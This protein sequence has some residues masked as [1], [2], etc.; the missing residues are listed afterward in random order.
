MKQKLKTSFSLSVP[1]KRI[2]ELDFLKGIAFLI[3]VWDH[4]VFD[5]GDLFGV[6]TSKLGFFENGIGEIAAVIFMTVCGVSITLG[7]HN[8][9]RG[10]TVFSLAMLLTAGTYIA[11]YVM[12]AELVILFGILHFLGLA[13][14]IGHFVKKLPTWAIPL[15][16]IEAFALNPLVKE[17][18]INT[19]VFFPIGI[20]NNLFYSSDYFP[21]IPNLGYVFIGIFIGKV[22]YKKKKSLFRHS[23]KKSFICCLGR[24]TLLLYFVHQPI[25][26]G[27]LY[28]ISFTGVFK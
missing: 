16:V 17:I 20:Y 14:I 18:S 10:L 22:F 3:M 8:I 1:S 26:Y 25:I 4:V 23:P 11:G 6:N 15:L 19:N 28:L 2:W 9:K 13:M 24:N 7:R 21:L 27:I 5:L 12:D